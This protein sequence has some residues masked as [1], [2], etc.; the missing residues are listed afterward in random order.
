MLYFAQVAAKGDEMIISTGKDDFVNNTFDKYRWSANTYET[1]EEIHSC[2]RDLGV[3]GKT[4]K[5]IS[6]IGAMTRY[7]L[8]SWKGIAV[9][10]LR[11]AGIITNYEVEH[12]PTK[13]T[14]TLNDGSVH[15]LDDCLDLLRNV[16]TERE[17]RLYEPLLILFEDGDVL[18]LLP[19]APKGL[20][21]GF[22]TL[23]KDIRDGLNRCEFDV[24]TLFNQFLS[25]CK[26]QTVEIRSSVKTTSYSNNREDQIRKRNMYC[27]Y[28]SSMSALESKYGW[29]DLDESQNSEYDVSFSRAD[30]I[31]CGELADLAPKSYQTPILEGLHGGG[32]VNIFPVKGTGWD[33]VPYEIENPEIFAVCYH[34]PA[35]YWPLLKKY[36]D[37]E[38]PIN[39]K[40]SQ[41][42]Y[43][44]YYWNFYTKDTIIKMVEEAHIELERVRTLSVEEQE[45]ALSCGY[46]NQTEEEKL[47]RIDEAKSF[48][49][50]FS[51]RLLSM[52][53]NTPEYNYISFDGP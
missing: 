3:F 35:L 21:I 50:R 13:E 51:E 18:E 37:P 14:V 7:S 15:D 10:T 39:K 6:A 43:D 38:L 29:L 1:A 48:T 22:N 8:G 42:H 36:F 11:E 9:S 23:P 33:E 32:A 25:G 45:N 4:V 30:T 53:L 19:C 5:G 20:R 52:A 46:R 49:E 41:G 34:E 24:G 17:V 44:S 47:I 31:K 12:L 40:C 16:L 26:L 2:L 28:F 27:I